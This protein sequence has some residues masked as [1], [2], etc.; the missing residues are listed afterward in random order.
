MP[1]GLARDSMLNLAEMAHQK[2]E[3]G[4]GSSSSQ[5]EYQEG[6]DEEK[7]MRVATGEI[8]DSPDE[9]P[10]QDDG[11]EE[12]ERVDAAAD[13][14][15]DE[16]EDWA[17]SRPSTPTLD[18]RSLTT[19]TSGDS[20]DSEAAATAPQ[21]PSAAALQ[22]PSPA[23]SASSYGHYTGFSTDYSHYES[24]G[25]TMVLGVKQEGER[26]WCCFFPWMAA[27]K[28]EDETAFQD[29]GAPGNESLVKVDGSSKIA[30]VTRIISKDEDEVSN[31]ELSTGSGGSG[32]SDVFGEKL[33]EKDRQAVI[34]RL[35]LAQPDS[36]ADAPSSPVTKPKEKGLLNGIQLDNRPRGILKH[37][38]STSSRQGLDKTNQ[39]QGLNGQHAPRRRSLFPQ[40][41]T[42]SQE[43]KN[44]KVDF[45]PMARVLTVKSQKEMEEQ[46]KGQ[47]WWQRS[48]YE[49]FR[50]T[51]RMITKAMLEGGSEVW[52][53]TN[54]S[55]QL[56]NQD[57]RSTLKHAY[58]LAER[59]AA[60]KKGDMKAKREYEDTRDKWWH[61]FGHSRRGLEH[62]AS[63]DE[64][65]QRQTNVRTAIKAVMD[66]QRRQR[67][68]HREDADKVRMV[69]IQ[70]TAWA[71]DLSMASGASDADAVRANFSEENRKSREFYLLKFSRADQQNQKSPT[72]KNMPAF[73]KPA[74]TMTVAPN[75]FDVNTVSQIRYR[76][77]QKKKASVA[78]ATTNVSTPNKIEPSTVPLKDEAEFSKDTMARKAAGFASGEDIGN[79]SA[80]LT[81]MG[82]MPKKVA[83][84]G[85]P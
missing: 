35:R 55:W 58:S 80:V 48:D 79:M 29:L 51:G 78:P 20:I 22:P 73:M 42:T 64:G 7:V 31:D 14:Q 83:A 38:T 76:Q 47:I 39:S 5:L 2:E 75:R 45:S 8:E 19:Q 10:D 65:R 63:I 25:G 84:A 40:Y 12:R 11:V 44:L 71:R 60:F 9:A 32:S 77:S 61:K 69:S 46:E 36:P 53:A 3:D 66:E 23:S 13:E 81:G 59:H 37:Q 26:L 18:P 27:T 56:K 43:K 17:G 41:G 15:Q 4:G 67:V 30:P 28:P 21:Q 6:D 16:T 33:S 82:H 24:S 74:M 34:A 85:G 57:K 70:H 72:Q 1:L 68:F 49:E 52:L 50:K 54:R 62:I